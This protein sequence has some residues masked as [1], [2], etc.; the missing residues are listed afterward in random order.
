M[1]DHAPKY[2]DTKFC[3]I[4]KED[5][6]NADMRSKYDNILLR[7]LKDKNAP[8]DGEAFLSVTPGWEVEQEY[9]PVEAGYNFKFTYK[10]RNAR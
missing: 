8:I 2:G 4:G 3:F 10:G 5:L 7:L 6:L 9:D 1:A